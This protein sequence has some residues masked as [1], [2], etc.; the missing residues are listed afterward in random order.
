MSITK[1]GIH[2]KKMIEIKIRLWTDGI[3]DEEDHIFPKKAWD[4]GVI[5][6]TPNDLHGI[7][8]NSPVVFN[9]FGS[10]LK[11][12]EKVLISQGIQLWPS[13]NSVYE[14]AD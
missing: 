9:S 1:K 11:T 8:S 5:Y 4:S 14:I 7:K 2:G 12:L 10:I 3:A 13:R 6:V